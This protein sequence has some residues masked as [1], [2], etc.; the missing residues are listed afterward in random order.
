MTQLNEISKLIERIDTKVLLLCTS[1]S[2]LDPSVNKYTVDNMWFDGLFDFTNLIDG[3]KNNESEDGCYKQ[4]NDAEPCPPFEFISPKKYTP[5]CSNSIYAHLGSLD[6]WLQIYKQDARKSYVLTAL[7]SDKFYTTVKADLIEYAKHFVEY[8]AGN[9]HVQVITKDNEPFKLLNIFITNSN[10]PQVINLGNGIIRL[11]EN[12]N[13]ECNDVS[14]W[15]FYL[16]PFTQ[17]IY[18]W[19]PVPHREFYRK[20]IH[21]VDG[22]DIESILDKLDTMFDRCMFDLEEI[23][24]ND[25]Q[26]CYKLDLHSLLEHYTEYEN[27]FCEESYY[28]DNDVIDQ[29]DEI[30]A[31]LDML[32]TELSK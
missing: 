14:A 8:Q 11:I 22:T 6:N 23:H 12:I 4:S 5:V 24:N 32:S 9:W 7:V 28:L 29:H 16:R 30:K 21:V 10:I 27:R 17:Q 26:I 20:Q 15:P 3:H 19:E 31:V 1:C 2:R 18:L 25:T 13:D